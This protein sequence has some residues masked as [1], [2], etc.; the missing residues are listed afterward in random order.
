ML[1]I[2]NILT[3]VVSNILPL[4]YPFLYQNFEWPYSIDVVSTLSSKHTGASVTNAKSLL[5]KSF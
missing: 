5:A 4:E 3:K 1:P 2:I